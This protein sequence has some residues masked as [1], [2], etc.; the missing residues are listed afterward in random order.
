MSDE[1]TVRAAEKNYITPAGFR[2][3]QSEF[4]TLR[5]RTRREVVI[6]GACDE[7]LTCVEDMCVLGPEID[8]GDKLST[9]GHDERLERVL[10]HLVQNALD[11]TPADGRVWLKVS[12]YS[13]QVQ[14]EVGDT[15]AGMS[16]EFVRSK[17]FRPFNTTK[18][19]GMGIG[20][21]ES[22]QYIHELGGSIAVHSAEGEGTLMTVL[23]PLFEMTFDSDL[24]GLTSR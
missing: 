2:R 24:M 3:L 20:T 21:Y 15:G 13:G 4:E 1:R 19:Q 8:I 11:A 17:L 12:R 18:H 7:G 23:L 16:E 10:G 9:R 14:V 22:Q 6:E 5:L